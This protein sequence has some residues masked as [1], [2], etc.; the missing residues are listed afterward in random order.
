MAFDNTYVK[1]TVG[2]AV[3]EGLRATLNAKPADPIIY[4]A[5]WLLRYRDLQDGCSKLKTDY[6][7]LLPEKE[8][9]MREVEV[10][11]QRLAEERRIRQEEEQRLAA[12]RRAAMEAAR[13]TPR[14]KVQGRDLVQA[15][16]SSG[17]EDDASYSYS[18]SV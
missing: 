10:E 7:R 9:Y 12:E 2:E 17:S 15:S 6:A 16:A 8:R 3:A 13:R 4:L 1:A 5:T 18:G 14:V 11:R